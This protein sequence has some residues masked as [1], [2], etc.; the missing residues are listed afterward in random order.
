MHGFPFRQAMNETSILEMTTASETISDVFSYCREVCIASLDRSY[1]K[2]GK[3]G[4]GGIIVKI[5]E[6]NIGRRKYKG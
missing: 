1:T 6:C 5:C 3:I 4:G 2:D